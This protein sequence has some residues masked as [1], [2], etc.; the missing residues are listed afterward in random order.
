MLEGC[1]PH[2]CPW[3]FWCSCSNI[4]T[5]CG[6]NPIFFFFMCQSLNIEIMIKLRDFLVQHRRVKY[7]NYWPFNY[8]TLY[9]KF[10]YKN[11]YW[12]FPFCCWIHISSYGYR[13]L[14]I[15]QPLWKEKKNCWTFRINFKRFIDFVSPWGKKNHLT[16]QCQFTHLWN[17]K[18]N[19]FLWGCFKNYFANVVDKIVTSITAFFSWIL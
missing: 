4:N 12:F 6:D 9:F 13:A 18:D 14:M 10:H 3:R 16:S 19:I 17:E 1:C 15:Q 5:W 8:L 7:S 11:D 2:A